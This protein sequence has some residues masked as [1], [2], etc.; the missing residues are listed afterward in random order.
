LKDEVLGDSFISWY[1]HKS[2]QSTT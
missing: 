2:N 1:P